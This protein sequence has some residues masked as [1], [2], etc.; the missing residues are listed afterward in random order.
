MQ[1]HVAVNTILTWKVPFC[2]EISMF[3]KQIWSK[4]FIARC[5]LV[6]YD[7]KIFLFFYFKKAGLKSTFLTHI[8]FILIVR[9]IEVKKLMKTHHSGRQFHFTFI[10]YTFKAG[11]YSSY[12]TVFGD[13]Q[14][15]C[16]GSC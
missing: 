10:L 9:Q 8:A 11:K 5:N 12:I 7:R 4:T 1:A 14:M 6:W 2:L 3:L 16:I 15:S 13:V